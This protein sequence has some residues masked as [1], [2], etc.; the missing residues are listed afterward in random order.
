ME[1]LCAALIGISAAVIEQ[2]FLAH[3]EKCAGA[4]KVNR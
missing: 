1:F 3:R 2:L 4:Q